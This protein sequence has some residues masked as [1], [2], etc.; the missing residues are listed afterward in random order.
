MRVP[1]GLERRAITAL[2]AS[3]PAVVLPTLPAFAADSKTYTQQPALAGKDYGKEAMTY[4]DFSKGAN[5]LLFKD[6]KAGTGQAPE[7][8]DRV[9]GTGSNHK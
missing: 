7:V 6:G 5:G 3:I 8:G 2:I 9:R 1:V 4:G